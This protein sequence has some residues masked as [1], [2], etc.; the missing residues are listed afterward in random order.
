MGRGSES[1][2]WRPCRP[3]HHRRS[4][5]TEA[6]AWLI[7]IQPLLPYPRP[8]PPNQR[9]AH[10]GGYGEGLPAK[11]VRQPVAGAGDDGPAGDYRSRSVA[12]SGRLIPRMNHQPIR[13]RHL[14]QRPGWAGQRASAHHEAPAPPTRPQLGL[15]LPPGPAVARRHAAGNDHDPGRDAAARRPSGG[16]GGLSGCPGPEQCK[17]CGDRRAAPGGRPAAA[18]YRNAVRSCISSGVGVSH[19]SPTATDRH[20]RGFAEAA[21]KRT[22][23]YCR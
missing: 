10:A 14:S 7:G 9:L 19:S 6:V 20:R 15:L 18:V 13:R 17:G 11:P 22:R 23:H 16:A 2:S 3:T 12:A 8:A 5:R 21:L 1:R 4:A